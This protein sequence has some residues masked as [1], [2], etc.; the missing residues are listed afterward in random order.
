MPKHEILSNIHARNYTKLIKLHEKPYTT[1][2]H[3]HTCPN[4]KFRPMSRSASVIKQTK[5]REKLCSS[6]FFTFLQI[7]FGGSED[8]I[9]YQCARHKNAASRIA[10]FKIKCAKHSFRGVD[11][12]SG[13]RRGCFYMHSR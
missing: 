10:P 3:L 8:A 1:T 11:P 2:I 12:S 4:M 9:T 6:L 5:H 13:L 7:V